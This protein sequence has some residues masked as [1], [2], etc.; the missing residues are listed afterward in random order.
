[1]LDRAI[2]YAVAAARFGSFTTAAERMGVTQSAITKS[3][4]ELEQRLGF[5][6]FNR[7]ARGVILTENGRAFT[8]RA[9]RL[10]DD[11]DELMR[12]SRRRDPYAAPLRV[13]VCPGSLEWLLLKPL[14]ATL[15]RYPQI[16]VVVSGSSFESMTQQL[17]NG[18]VDVAIGFEVAF[19]EQP[20]FRREELAPLE[21]TYFVRKE[22]ALAAA[23]K[24]S[25]SDLAAFD[26]VTPTISQPYGADIRDIF[27]SQD[28]NASSHI[29]TV[30]YFPLV[31]RIVSSSEAIGVVSLSYAQSPNFVSKFTA[32]DL[33]D[34]I[35][36]SPLCCA[37]RSR[38]E[39]P[40]PVRAFVQACRE[41]LPPGGK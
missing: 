8:D 2:Q 27:E 35:P 1:M 25:R 24:I 39:A 11:M 16:R 34:P 18:A 38:W 4:G 9:A 13:G 40:P 6:V 30:D 12:T 17:R 15:R 14:T 20:D 32:I 37:M 22:H 21:T 5:A 19:A 10:I 23:S 26:F 41:S 28:L 7:T 29:H 3:M 33:A 31:Q 36:P